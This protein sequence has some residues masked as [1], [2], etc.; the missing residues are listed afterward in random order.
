MLHLSDRVPM[1]EYLRRSIYALYTALLHTT[2]LYYILLYLYT[3]TYFPLHYYLL[4]PTTALPLLPYQHYTTTH[5]L[6][7]HLLPPYLR[8]LFYPLFTPFILPLSFTPFMYLLPLLT[9]F[10]IDLT[11]LGHRVHRNRVLKCDVGCEYCRWTYTCSL[12]T[13]SHPFP[14]RVFLW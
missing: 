9:D 3:T 10:I 1:M 6:T 13:D 4:P 11:D 8:P 14:G 5:P 2:P 7:T 12:S